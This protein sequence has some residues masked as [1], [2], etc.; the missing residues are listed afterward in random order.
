M[1]GHNI[2]RLIINALAPREVAGRKQAVSRL[3][4]MHINGVIEMREAKNVKQCVHCGR[5]TIG[6]NVA[7]T[8]TLECDANAVTYWL[9]KDPEANVITPNGERIACALRGALETAH[10]I[11]HTLHKCYEEE[12]RKESLMC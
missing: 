9:S 11:G 2:M 6:I 5:E 10:G 12:C 8:G 3:E 7:G 1:Q 4:K